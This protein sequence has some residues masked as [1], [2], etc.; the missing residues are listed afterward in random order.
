MIVFLDQSANVVNNRLP[1]RLRCPACRQL[2]SFEAVSDQVIQS[3]H[4]GKPIRLGQRRCPN[5]TCFAH[6]FLVWGHNGEV[7]ASYPP[8]RIDFDPANIPPQIVSTFEEAL[9]C[10]ANQA[11][12]AAA[13]MVRRTLEEICVDRAAT[14]KT[15]KDR[16]SA[17][18]K[19]VILP[20]ALISGLDS[21]RLLGND[22]AHV[23]AKEYTRIGK[24]EVELAIDV[25]KEVLKSV[26]QLQDLV[27]RLEALKKSTQP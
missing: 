27:A 25:T 22:A 24:T 18:S 14:G 10:H 6:V 1:I 2:G 7:R 3:N 21:L 17:L 16:V 13:I 4:G 12:V 15:L 5:P 11:Y 19:T 23:E 26:Y 9:T 8:E 20:P